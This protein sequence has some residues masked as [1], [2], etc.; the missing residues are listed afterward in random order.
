MKS[1]RITVLGTPRFKAFLEE[2]AKK[3][4]ISVSE[5]V[6]RRCEG[7][8]SQDEEMLTLLA[9][10]LKRSVGEAKRSLAEGLSDVRAALAEARAPG[11]RKA[12]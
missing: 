9:A 7:R 1:E 10:E 8:P 4:K 5:L 12:A 11:R 6:R 2:Q 3:E